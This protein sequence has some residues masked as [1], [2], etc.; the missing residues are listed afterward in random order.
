[1][2]VHGDLKQLPTFK[3]AAVTIGTF[4]GVHA[5]HQKIIEQLKQ[6]TAL[7]HGESV[8]ITFDPHPRKVL[9]P[10]K[11]LKLITTLEE[12]IELLDKQGIDHL[13]VVP[14]TLEFAQIS[15]DSYIRD[16]LVGKF[17]PHTVIIGYDHHFGHD[18]KGDY[19]MMEDA[20]REF[21]FELKEIPEHLVDSIIVSSTQIR[22]A[23]AHGR[24]DTANHL[25]GYDFFFSGRVIEGNKLGRTLGYP[26][27]NLKIENKEKLIPGN[28]VYA[29]E[30]EL[31][32]RRLKG[33]MN[34]GIRP[35]LTDGLFMIEVNLF[36]FN[37]EIYGE[38]LRVYV[39][40]F[41][42]EEI[43]FDGMDELKSQITRDKHEVLEFFGDQS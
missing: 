32:G 19:H 2:Q 24:I 15:A 1:M 8:I 36:D 34:V 25:L 22:E 16:F 40:K 38:V 20:A 42:R 10:F 17:N 21:Q 35:T 28:G 29:V 39:K 11:P 27:A 33:M 31:N 6:E 3:N 41:L 30:A 12:K 43:R 23:V 14:F 37:E 5:G 9:A 7:I 18:R 4:D 26:T 13:I